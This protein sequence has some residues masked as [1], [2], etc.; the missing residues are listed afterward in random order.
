[1]QTP[2]MNVIKVLSH[3]GEAASLSRSLPPEA[4]YNTLISEKLDVQDHYCAWRQAQELA[5]T[6]SREQLPREAPFSFCSYPFLLTARAK[7][8]LL[9]LEA[10]FQMEQVQCCDAGGE[11]GGGGRRP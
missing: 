5:A 10:T 3:V 6:C 8:H 1:M 4:F 2:I 7:S 11:G 9:H